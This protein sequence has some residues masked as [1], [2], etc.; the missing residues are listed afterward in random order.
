MNE[1]VLSQDEIDALLN[2]DSNNDETEAVE[3]NEQDDNN[4]ELEN[5][6]TDK[7]KD[8]IGEIGNISMGS[9]ATALYSLLDE[10]V[11]IT[12][13][14]V[15]LVTFQKL[16][17]E[18]E[19]PCV[20]VDVEYIEGLEGSNLLIIEQQDAAIISDLM[21]GGD[22]NNPDAELN[23]LH[24]SAVSEAM[25]QM[26]GSAST[27]MSTIMQ[28]DKV[29]ISPPNAELLT[30][31]TDEIKSRSFQP[32][33]EVVKVSFD[34]TIGEVI[35]SEILQLMPLDFAKELVAYLTDPDPSERAEE[36]QESGETAADNISQN[37][38]ATKSKA[39]AE[40]QP[41]QQTAQQQ[42]QQQQ[43]AQQLA[44]SKSGAVSREESVDVQSVE[45]S[46]LGEG[47]T[48]Q[49]QSKIDLIKDVPLEVTVRLGKT[50][51]LIKDILELGN[52]SVIELDKLAGESV[53]LLVNG[54]LIAKGEVVVI[55][56][57]FGFRV[58]DIVSPM[59]RITNL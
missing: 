32:D 49:G 48:E 33:D 20:V 3:S 28:G 50:K 43:A 47:Q 16:I 54:K 29:N 23:E 59:E 8:A 40:Q 31:N 21:M 51:M 7:E 5:E 17:Q 53:D 37:E 45:F 56:E 27:S 18:Y 52:G 1:E 46:Q 30:L 4:S 9:A 57:N 12:A 22:G 35:D 26:M 38:P 19:R 15:E 14:E 34:L 25:N 41:Q 11:E 58:T 10:T 13:P 2:D 36:P 55:D 44:N 6:L 42:P 24:L 39:E